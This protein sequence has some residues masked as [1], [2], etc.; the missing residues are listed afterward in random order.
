[1]TNRES[2]EVAQVAA[3]R[4][5]P[6]AFN[7]QRQLWLGRYLSRAETFEDIPVTVKAS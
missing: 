1:M 6:A 4:M 5:K 2:G 7:E 3:S